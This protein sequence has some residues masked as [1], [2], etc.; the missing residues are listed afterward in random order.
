MQK[1]ANAAINGAV[2]SSGYGTP[3]ASNKR[4]SEELSFGVTAKDHPINRNAQ[5][6]QVFLLD[7]CLYGS[8]PPIGLSFT[9]M[10]FYVKLCFC[11][12]IL[13]HLI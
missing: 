1:A 8:R 7:L 13:C 2:G 3:L 4:K 5:S 12:S 9:Y 11:T 6:Q 10:E